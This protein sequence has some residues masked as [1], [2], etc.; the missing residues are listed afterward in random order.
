MVIVVVKA[1]EIPPL[2]GSFPHRAKCDLPQPPQLAQDHRVTQ[3]M[4]AVEV[5][6]LTIRGGA[7]LF[8]AFDGLFELAAILRQGDGGLGLQPS[9]LA[10]ANPVE[11]V[12]HQP[13]RRLGGQF[14]KT[15]ERNARP[16][17]HRQGLPLLAKQLTHQ[18]QGGGWLVEP[19]A[20]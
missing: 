13:R 20:R 5:D 2:A 10:T 19:E 8:A 14:L 1:I 7:E 18:Q 6:P 9:R 16:Y 4:A 17:G 15:A 3:F 11:V 12:A